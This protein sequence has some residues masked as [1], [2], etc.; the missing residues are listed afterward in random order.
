VNGL[1]PRTSDEQQ[2]SCT[3]GLFANIT[4]SKE[5]Y[6]CDSCQLQLQPFLNSCSSGFLSTSTLNSS[7]GIRSR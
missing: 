4:G 5:A 2:R 3:T 6:I 1:D 7:Q